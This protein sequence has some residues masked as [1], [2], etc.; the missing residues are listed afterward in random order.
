MTLINTGAVAGTKVVQLYMSDLPA[1]TDRPPHSLKGF[2][3][4]RL[5]AG[6]SNHR[7]RQ[8]TADLVRHALKGN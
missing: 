2:Q 5:E 4:V 1:G 7:V 6:E 8:M 3:K